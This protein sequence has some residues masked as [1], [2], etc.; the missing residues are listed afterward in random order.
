MDQAHFL[1]PCLSLESGNMFWVLKPFRI[2]GGSEAQK[3]PDSIML[4]LGN[5]L[6]LSKRYQEEIYVMGLSDFRNAQNIKHTSFLK[7]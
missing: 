5:S 2:E 7:T 1:S 3:H 6:E 4:M